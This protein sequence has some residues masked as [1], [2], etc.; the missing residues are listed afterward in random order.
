MNTMVRRRR[1]SRRKQFEIK[2]I[3]GPLSAMDRCGRSEFPTA[4]QANERR[5]VA[6][7]V[8]IDKKA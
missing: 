4:A 1:A 6:G 5:T 7:S 3:V 8:G 2:N